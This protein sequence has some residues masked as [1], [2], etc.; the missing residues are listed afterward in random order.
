MSSLNS[1]NNHH[2][3]NDILLSTYYGYQNAEKHLMY[4]PSHKP[5]GMVGIIMTLLKLK[6]RPSKLESYP[7]SQGY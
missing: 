6:Q 2:Q 3:N 7:G 1:I 4:A 5:R